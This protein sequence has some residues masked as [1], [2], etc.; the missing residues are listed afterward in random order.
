MK[1]GAAGR[2]GAEECVEMIALGA[3][4]MRCGQKPWLALPVVWFHPS[5]TP[6]PLPLFGKLL[7][8]LFLP[9]FCF[10]FCFFFFLVFL[11]NL[12]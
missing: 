8:L 11:I 6:H 1:W 3:V 12:F 5:A 2:L 10:F 4:M 7:K 9:T